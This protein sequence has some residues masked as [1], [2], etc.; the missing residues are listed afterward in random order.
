MAEPVEPVDLV[1]R[2]AANLIALGQ[3]ARRAR[4]RVLAAGTR[5]AGSPARRGRRRRRGSARLMRGASVSLD[6]VETGA[7]RVRRAPSEPSRSDAPRDGPSLGAQ[8]DRHA[9]VLDARLP[10]ARL[11][12]DPLLRRDRALLVLHLSREGSFRIGMS[13]AGLVAFAATMIFLNQLGFVYSRRQDVGIDRRRSSSAPH[14]SSSASSRASSASSGL[15]ADS[16]SPRSSRSSASASSRRANG[17]FSGKVFGDGL[18]LITAATWGAVLGRD[19]AADAPLLAVSDQPQWCWHSAGCRSPS[20]ARARPPTRDST[21][22][23]HVGRL[24]LRGHRPAVPDE[25]PLVHGDLAR[26]A[27][28]GVALREHAALLRGRVRWCSSWAST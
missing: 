8:L 13:D 17:G 24:R 23:A 6:G 14:R 2:V 21:S 9:Y 27:R 22:A 1:V 19:H 18:A 5:N 28:A 26:R 12:D 3:V 11:R 7:T 16:G 20:S 4:A 10:A 25:H 15:G